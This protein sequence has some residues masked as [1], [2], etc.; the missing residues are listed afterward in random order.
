[1]TTDVDRGLSRVDFYPTLRFPFTRWPYLT[2]NS[3]LIWRATYWTESL[4]PAQGNRQVGEPIHRTYFDMST[5]IT[6]PVFTRIWSPPDK[7]FKH[8]IE[9]TLTLQRI[10]PIDNASRIVPIDGVDLVTGSVTRVIYGLNNRLYAKKDVAREILTLSVSQ[11]Y[12]TDPNAAA[13]DAQYQSGYSP[14]LPPTHLSPVAIQL[15]ASPATEFDAT[16]RTEYD[17]QVHALRTIQANGTW[18]RPFVSATVGW[19]QRRVIADLPGYNNPAFASN[20][21]IASTTVR[22]RTNTFG[23]VYSFNY[24]FH[25]SFFQTQRYMAYYN[26]Q[27][28]GVA[29]EFQSVNYGLAFTN[30]GVTQDHRF[31]LSFTLAGIG[32][33]SNLL[34]AFGGQQAR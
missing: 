15:R 12:Y 32:T 25:R 30:V 34:G 13:R 14:G 33:F 7:K 5:R 24:D 8:V 18:S 23:G 21:L 20:G 28:C 17:T 1:V 2:F 19:S 11:S 29:A 4:D 9:P 6:G 3:S 16:F 31:N 10:T 22:S 27:C 26:S